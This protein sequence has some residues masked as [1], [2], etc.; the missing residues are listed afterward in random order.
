MYDWVVPRFILSDIYNLHPE[1]YDGKPQSYI[2]WQ[3]SR[4]W[5]LRGK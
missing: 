4:L 5:Q 2:I 1:E 3:R